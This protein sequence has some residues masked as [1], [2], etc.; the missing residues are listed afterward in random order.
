MAD[1]PALSSIHRAAAEGPAEQIP[2]CICPSR[3]KKRRFAMLGFSMSAAF[4]FYVDED[5]YFNIGSPCITLAWS[6]DATGFSTSF[7]PLTAQHPSPRAAVFFS[8]SLPLKPP[9]RHPFKNV[10]ARV[11]YFSFSPRR[12]GIQSMNQSY[13]KVLF[14]EKSLPGC[15]KVDK[16][17]AELLFLIPSHMKRHIFH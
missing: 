2:E 15:R 4:R 17:T 8:P 1:S 7:L 12:N 6:M 13:L 14:I 11:N 9:S 5:S 16:S 3:L 10:P